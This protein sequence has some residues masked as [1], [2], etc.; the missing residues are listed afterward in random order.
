MTRELVW[1][2][3]G[4]RARTQNPSRMTPGCFLQKFTAP[5]S[6]L[7]LYLALPGLG[8]LVRK[9]RLGGA[10]REKITFGA[11]NEMAERQILVR[12]ILVSCLI[13]SEYVRALPHWSTPTRVSLAENFNM[14]V[15]LGDEDYK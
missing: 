8:L 2:S 13:D 4:V 6:H 1:T 9:F 7:L 10:P 3:V 14:V 12:S 11:E 5:A 15:D